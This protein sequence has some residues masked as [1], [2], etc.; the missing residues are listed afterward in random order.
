MI[1]LKQFNTYLSIKTI[2]FKNQISLRSEN[3]KNL[4]LVNLNILIN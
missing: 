4:R 2:T 3:D 1:I